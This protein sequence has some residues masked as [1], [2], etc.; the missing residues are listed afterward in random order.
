MDTKHA[1]GT[2]REARLNAAAP[3]MLATLVDVLDA[4]EGMV[5][6]R[7][8]E[9]GTPGPNWAM[10]LTASIEA[11]IAKAGGAEQLPCPNGNAGCDV[12]VDHHV[13]ADCAGDRI[14]AAEHAMGDR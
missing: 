1:L 8:G 12:A 14:D 3:L 5:D 2:K 7:D 4:I 9:D 11:V 13:C 10:N 6:T